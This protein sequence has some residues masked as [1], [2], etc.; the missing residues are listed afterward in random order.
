MTKIILENDLILKAAKSEKTARPPVWMMRQAG[1]YLPQYQAIRSKMS[2]LELCKNPDK[3]AEVS[4]QPFEILGVDAIIMFS[5]ILIPLEPMGADLSFDTGKPEFR[6]PI[7]TAAQI[8]KLL[9]PNDI[10]S[11]CGFVY[12]TL[13]TIKERIGSAV[14]VL[15]FAG[16]PWTLASY[17]IEGGGSKNFDNIKALMYREPEA[18][19]QLLEKLS[20]TIIEYLCVKLKHGADML[21]LFD[22]WASV[23][24]GDDYRQFALPYQQK[25]ISGIKARYPEALI[26]LYVNGVSS[27][28]DYMVESGADVLSID[29]RSNLREIREYLSSY[30]N[31][32]TSRSIA[33]QGNFD[34]CYLFGDKNF[35]E[36]RTLQMLG[37][38]GTQGGYI[39][40]LGH[41]ILP[42]I[43]PEHAKVFINTVKNFKYN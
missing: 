10:E 41:G 38:A 35:I 40:N 39:A 9:V 4:I 30:K 28:I 22:T 14:P 3:A 26:T 1:R 5:D 2:F 34:P 11:S 31:S 21:Q 27:V 25:I 8:E 13:R 15:G 43:D 37:E 20:E 24:S 19:H 6:T 29:W 18:M 16:A 33:V 42:N 17:L 23:L 32:S 7:R 36:R 12:E